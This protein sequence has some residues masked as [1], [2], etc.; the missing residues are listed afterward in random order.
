MQSSQDSI[1]WTEIY[2]IITVSAAFLED[3][4]KVIINYF[5]M[6][7]F[8][9]FAENLAH[10]RISHTN[11]GTLAQLGL[12]DIDYLFSTVHSILYRHRTSLWFEG[13]SRSVHCG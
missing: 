8:V 6:R 10:C 12:M 1:H 7:M 3:I 13:S 11:V 4:R 9:M 5:N 2:V